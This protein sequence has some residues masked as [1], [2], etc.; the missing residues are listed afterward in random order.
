[1]SV[2]TQV[3]LE[4]R[5]IEIV[6]EVLAEMF[7]GKVE[8]C[9][10]CPLPIRG[11]RGDDRSKL[12]PTNKNYAPPCHLIVRKENIGAASNDMGIHRRSDGSLTAYISG[13]DRRGKLNE[14]WV[15]EVKAKLKTKYAEKMVQRQAKRAGYKVSREI[16]HD[17]TVRLRLKRRR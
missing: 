6:E 8:N 4:L 13:Y 17:G 3:E 2:F 12:A 9:I 7:G 1:M 5:D 15:N 11:Y 16:R 10:D 14:K